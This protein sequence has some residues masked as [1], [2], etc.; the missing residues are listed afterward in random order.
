MKITCKR[1]QLAGSNINVVSNY[2]EHDILLELASLWSYA[3]LM[4]AKTLMG[5]AAMT[6]MRCTDSEQMRNYSL[7]RFCCSS[8]CTLFLVNGRAKTTRFVNVNVGIF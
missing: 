5:R 3:W 7:A 6:A 8:I 2:Q 1:L 4:T